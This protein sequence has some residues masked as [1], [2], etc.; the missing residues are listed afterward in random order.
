MEY[1]KKSND[2]THISHLSNVH[3]HRVA[4][5]KVHKNFDRGFSGLSTVT[6]I[7]FLEKKLL[8]FNYFKCNCFNTVSTARD[9]T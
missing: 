1:K 8:L 5:E 3:T 2:Q 7:L 4:V 9:E 6:G